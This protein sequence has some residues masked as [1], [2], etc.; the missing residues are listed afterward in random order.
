MASTEEQHRVNQN[1]GD[2]ACLAQSHQAAAQQLDMAEI[3]VGV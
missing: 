3:V 2:G 1:A